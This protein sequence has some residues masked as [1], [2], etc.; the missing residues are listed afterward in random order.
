[1]KEQ[2]N[3][4]EIEV[5]KIDSIVCGINRLYHDNDP[6]FEVKDIVDTMNEVLR[7]YTAL[8]V[9]MNEVADCLNVET[10]DQVTEDRI[11]KAVNIIDNASVCSPDS[12]KIISWNHHFELL[13]EVL[14]IVSFFKK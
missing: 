8:R 5:T 4:N 12:I 10:G 13:V 2:L 11:K 1:M 14:N 3:S 7:E 9:V 6:F